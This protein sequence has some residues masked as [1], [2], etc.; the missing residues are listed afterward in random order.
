MVDAGAAVF[1]AS[2]PFAELTSWIVVV[3]S[4]KIK[5]A[6]VDQPSSRPPNSNHDLFLVQVSL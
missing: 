6:A 3:S 2:H 1:S 4:G 5:K